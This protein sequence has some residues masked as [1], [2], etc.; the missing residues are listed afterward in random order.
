MRPAGGHGGGAP[1]PGGALTL[2]DTLGWVLAVA[3]CVTLAL[4]AAVVGAFVAAR[5]FGS[6]RFE[7]GIIDAVR[8]VGG[9]TSRPGDPAAAW[10]PTG[11]GL[12]GPI[13][14]WSTTMITSGC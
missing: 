10:G 8:A 6:G 12:P 5:L 9:L 11:D 13:A 1:A 7:G 4:G 3:A 14:Y 2:E